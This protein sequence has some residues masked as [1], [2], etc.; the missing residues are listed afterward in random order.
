MKLLHA[1]LWRL[2]VDKKS[3][4][5]ESLIKLFFNW[6][7]YKMFKK[8]L[9]CACHYL[10]LAYLNHD[11]GCLNLRKSLIS[12]FVGKQNF[13]IW[14][15]EMV[16]LTPKHRRKKKYQPKS[17]LLIFVLE[18]NVFWCS[19]MKVRMSQRKK[20]TI[21]ILKKTKKRWHFV[22]TKH[23]S[24]NRHQKQLFIFETLQQQDEW[25]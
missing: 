17:F 13:N 5:F 11:F 21:N 1:C 25:V 10:S 22:P 2:N 12:D 7:D 4:R 20:S 16:I 19:D 9:L 3:P 14:S 15:L 18:K 23:I 6:K 24:E 8:R